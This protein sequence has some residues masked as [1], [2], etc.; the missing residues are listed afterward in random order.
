MDRTNFDAED[1][2]WLVKKINEA[3]AKRNTFGDVPSILVIIASLFA[4]CVGMK[5]LWG[6]GVAVFVGGIVGLIVGLFTISNTGATV[7][8]NDRY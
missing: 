8:D 1:K 3:V 5:L 7:D 4:L 2:K 6:L